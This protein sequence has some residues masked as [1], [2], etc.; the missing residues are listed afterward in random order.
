M[1]KVPR[2]SG[3]TPEGYKA[4]SGIEDNTP[5]NPIQHI[6]MTKDRGVECL[7][8]LYTLRSALATRRHH[9]QPTWALF[10]DLVKSF[11]STVNHDGLLFKLATGDSRWD[12]KISARKQQQAT[13]NA[14][15]AVVK[16]T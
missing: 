2:E 15:G 1:K 13:K 16:S 5:E 10:V 14:F 8:G 7:D 12:P 3:V 6:K 9:N 4:M 11:D